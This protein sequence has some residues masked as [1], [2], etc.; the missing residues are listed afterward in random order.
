ME[1]NP[2]RQGVIHKAGEIQ[3]GKGDKISFWKDLWVGD[4]PLE[5]IFPELFNCASNQEAKVIDYMER[6]GD[7][8]IWGSIFRKN[9]NEW[10]NFNSV[11]C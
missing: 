11:L 6:R 3:S 1:R 5:S 9:L 8:I 2:D 4:R 10:R 7:C